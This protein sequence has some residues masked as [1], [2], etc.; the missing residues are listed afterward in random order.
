MVS[1]YIKKLL[2]D[3]ARLK[4]W[5][6]ITLALSCVVVFCVVY[7]LT[8]PA[9]TLEGKTIC[10][11][12]EHTHT[13]ECY[14][15]DKLICGKEEH[16]HTEDCYEKEEEQP[17]KNEVLNEPEET[18]QP[19]TQI[20]S[21]EEENTQP[22][23]TEVQTVSEPELKDAE[24][25]TDEQEEPKTNLDFVLN[26]HPDYIESTILY[27]KNND[28][29]TEISNGESPNNTSLKILVKFQ[30]IHTKEFM[31]KCNCKFTYNLPNFLSFV[32]ITAPMM[33]KDTNEKIG[34]INAYNGKVVV[35]YFKDYLQ[36]LLN[37]SEA[38]TSTFSGEFYV[39]GKID[40]SSLDSNGQLDTNINGI[41]LNYGMDFLE[42]FG[43]ISVNK[44]CS[45]DEK[46]K[47]D[48]YIKYSL[49]VKAGSN[50]A[51]NIIV[52]DRFTQSKDLVSY[53]G[54]DKTETILEGNADKPHPFETIENNT[55]SE[56]GKVYL[57]VEKNDKTNPIPDANAA[58]KLNPGSL[59]W[60]IG[61]MAP[62]EK[63]VLTY[64][65]K[66]ADNKA[67]NGNTITNEAHVYSKTNQNNVYDRDNS[68]ANFVP[69]I[70]YSDLMK[71]S[72]DGDIKRDTNGNYLI[73]YKLEFG[74]H[75][76]GSNYSLKNFELFDD[77]NYAGDNIKTD[78]R[79]LEYISYNK[80]SV[81]LYKKGY[82]K[83]DFEEIKDIQILWSLNQGEYKKD[84][85]DSD[86]NPTRFKL[87]GKTDKPITVNPGD[88]L[89][90]TYTLTVK[91]EAFAAIKS[92]T[93]DVKNRYLFSASNA[94]K[95]FNDAVDRVY[96]EQILNEYSWSEKRV[97]E[98]T[99]DEKT[100]TISNGEG[101]YLIENGHIKQ[102]LS[103]D[104]SFVVPKGSYEYTVDVNKT[105]N[106]FDVTSVQM[107]DSL[108]T[109]KMVYVGYVKVESLQ[110]DS[111]KDIYQ[112]EE[113]KWVKID[114]LH[115]FSLIP[116]DMDWKN[117]K[118]AYR[119]T[120]YVA[121]SKTASFTE[122]NLKNTFTLSGK[123]NRNGT[124]I[125]ISDI[126]SNSK[127]VIVSGNYSMNVH[128]KA[129]DYVR[130]EKD[131]TSWTNGKLY[132]L[133]EVK[134]TSIPKGTVFQDCISTDKDLKTSYLHSDSLV[135]VYQGVIPD[136]INSND[137]TGLL[138]NNTLKELDKNLFEQSMG[139]SKNFSGEDRYSELT[140][141]STQDITLG[142]DNNLYFVVTSE[143]ESL[144]TKYRETYV[145]KNS[146][147]TSD[148]GVNFIE[149]GNATKDLCG[150]K[151]ILK[152]LGQTFTYDGQNI[153]SN[154]DG[155]DKNTVGG[156]KTK[157]VKEELKETGAGLYASWAFKVNYSGDLSGSY[158]VLEQ[159]PD[160]M[161]LAYIRIKWI[162][163]EQKNK[164]SIQSKTIENLEEGEG[165]TPKSITA[166]DD[167]N[168]SRKTIYYVKG[169]QALIELG[170]FYAGKVTDKY[171][172]DVQVVCKV[173]DPK[174]LLGSEEVK[175]TNNVILQNADGTE[176]IDSAHSNVTLSMKNITKSQVQNGQK[177]NYTIETNSLNQDLPSNG[178]DNKLKLVDE[179]G[180]NL[181]LDLDT[182]KVEDTQ[183]KQVNTRIS[184]ENNKLEI[185]IPKDKKLKITYTATVNAA[186]GEKVSVTNT[187]YW[188]GYSSSNGET[189]KIEN[190]TYDAGG[191]TQSSNSP[192]LKIIKRDASNINL[193]L[194]GA[195]FKVAKCEL[196]NDEIVEVQTDKTWS[197]TTNDQGEITF[198]SS[199]QWVLDYN[200]IY[201]VT[202]E[203]APN[204]YI[205]DDTVRYIMCIKK[206]NGT[207][208]DYVNQC[209]KRDDIIKCNSTA[210]FKLDLTNQKKGIVIKKNF[211]NDAA[212]NSKKSVSGTYRFGLY[213]N[214]DLKNPVDIVSIEFGPS[215]QEEKEAKFVNL[216]LNKIYYVYELDN[217]DNPIMDSNVHVINGLEYL[218]TYSTNNAVKNGD[219]VTVTNQSRVKQ[220]PSTGSYGTL[221]YRISGAMLVLASLIVLININKKN[222]LNE[223]SKNRRKK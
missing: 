101:K 203:S 189:V 112:T 82:G 16:Q 123:V 104:N 216:D 37:G 201:K 209:L 5:K 172:V 141:K 39:E 145:F 136:E 51:K 219:T 100:I 155:T 156:P 134:G 84:W 153:K 174:V 23:T 66:L 148:D 222:H 140:L 96:N 197:E 129:W 77:L 22:E 71:K 110:Y 220:L 176:N 191:S 64:Y 28:Q 32:G 125:D 118:N 117:G 53:I 80:D 187:A 2:K 75:K 213:D 195:V 193:R 15:D 109:D 183:G 132:W 34:E 184:Y 25:T 160:G 135:G 175:F 79:A 120:Y 74:L 76:D 210:D 106:E 89:Y 177:I 58:E 144:P 221:I 154:M 43:D 7:A 137:L 14:Q 147:K 70:K 198:G 170:D 163:E 9:I 185:E 62:N 92:G 94:G 149:R 48:D 217:K 218:T 19:D 87:T 29:W 67:L 215:D 211:I 202:E 107:K 194:Q 38:E 114:S 21:Q 138:N 97:G 1:E 158:R 26:E 46:D 111:T 214:T 95:N 35:T 122:L 81:K 72:V 17:V 31:E 133:I 52:V 166:D 169:N 151:N 205:K 93:L 182:I 86:G 164:G 152:E 127:E 33:D 30:K 11:M 178:A 99:N 142:N 4:K 223:K 6:R 47:N 57:G 115:E 85:T 90:V 44:I 36:K 27:V 108:N 10:G 161:Q 3:K 83:Q 206:E 73:P 24:Q 63:R 13:E 91:P 113:T 130:A 199:A 68:T 69:Q 42:R 204:G 56:H 61:N 168:E 102:D 60:N 116:S 143:P 208:S 131:A 126:V 157:I 171:S 121:Q 55:S 139:S 124:D 18:V 88:S 119:F 50:G 8:L 181:I 105:K 188:K 20:T 45:K 98:K 59:V 128:K 165:W 167:D 207:Y 173:T 162:G 65:V 180:S 12:E 190:F 150:G 196:K 54:I 159:V 192:Q 41:K 212:G 78:S 49:T 186:P 103:T 179:L 200:T 40:L 146:I